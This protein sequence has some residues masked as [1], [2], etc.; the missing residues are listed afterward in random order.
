MRRCF[1]CVARIADNGEFFEVMPA[2]AKNLIIGFARLDGRT[3]GIVGNQVR[4][5]VR[6]CRSTP[7]ESSIIS[8]LY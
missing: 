5:C 6:N 1:A 3:V 4:A 7:S 8:A 2:Y